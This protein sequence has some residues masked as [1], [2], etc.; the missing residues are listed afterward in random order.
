MINVDL[1]TLHNL[2]ISKAE[3][4]NNGRTGSDWCKFC[5]CAGHT[6]DIC[7]KR[8]YK[9]QSWNGDKFL[10]QIGTSSY[11]PNLRKCYKWGEIGEH[12]AKN[13]PKNF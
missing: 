10:G 8:M 1:G 5:K 2:K 9:E 3:Y 12:I 13:C 11:K 7:K 4:N 6:I